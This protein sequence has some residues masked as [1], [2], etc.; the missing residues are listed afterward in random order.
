MVADEIHLTRPDFISTPPFFFLNHHCCIQAAGLLQTD[1]VGKRFLMIILRYMESSRK[2]NKPKPSDWP[3]LSTYVPLKG[4]QDSRVDFPPSTVA[5]ERCRPHFI[6]EPKIE[7]CLMYVC[8][9][10]E[11]N[12][13]DQVEHSKKIHTTSKTKYAVSER[14]KQATR[15]R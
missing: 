1:T 7:I 5:A 11:P 15:D 14:A 10:A 6:G 12:T 8:C 3:V 4:H 2:F 13:M 9:G